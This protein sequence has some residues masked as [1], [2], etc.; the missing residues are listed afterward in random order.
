MAVTFDCTL[1]LMVAASADRLVTALVRDGFGV[2]PGGRD[3]T[4][5]FE[6][7]VS[8]FCCL[9][10]TPKQNTESYTTA[11]SMSTH[12]RQTLQKLEIPCFGGIVKDDKSTIVM[13]GCMPRPK[14][15]P[16]KPKNPLDNVF[17]I[18]NKDEEPRHDA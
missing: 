13:H 6:G 8:S 12:L 17:P 1:V 7:E 4:L 3:G 10:I 2:H 11:S 9:D 15:K 14:P 16:K 18:R 5:V